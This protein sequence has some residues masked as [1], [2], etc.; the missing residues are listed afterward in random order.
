[1]VAAEALDQYVADR[2]ILAKLRLGKRAQRQHLG[3]RLAR[4]SH[5][6]IQQLPA[7]AF[8]AQRIV[9]IRVVDDDHGGIGAAVR[10]LGHTLAVF[11]DIKRAFGIG[12]LVLDRV[13]HSNEYVDKCA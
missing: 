11:G 12:F 5:Q 13:G 3:A 4:P 7:N 1:M 9:D 10:H 6:R 2:R 8:A